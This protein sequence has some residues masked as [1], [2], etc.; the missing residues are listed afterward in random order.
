MSN[1]LTPKKKA[2]KLA[3]WVP[4]F[5]ATFRE[6]GNVRLSCE[7]VGVARQT[8]YAHAEASEEF[9]KQW[10]MAKEEAID[11]LEAAARARGLEQ[12]DTLLI[13]LLK[14]HRRE[15]YGDVARNIIVNVPAQQSETDATRVP[16]DVL[17]AFL[18]Q[19][20]KKAKS[21]ECKQPVDSGGSGKGNPAPEG[22]T[23]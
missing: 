7:A 11:V 18:A 15:V 4:L 2:L 17:E 19:Q 23:E 16:S 5:L 13:F 1:R 10:D 21:N 6:T 14:S 8:V 22:G 3:E 20:F 9:R 12:S